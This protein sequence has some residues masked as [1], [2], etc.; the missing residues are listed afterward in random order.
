MAIASYMAIP[1]LGATTQPRSQSL[2]TERINH[3]GALRVAPTAYADFLSI[4][5]DTVREALGSEWTP[6][7][8][9]QSRP[10]LADGRR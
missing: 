4:V 1:R 8:E 9:A 3:E 6:V 5:L 10:A 2:R 7:M